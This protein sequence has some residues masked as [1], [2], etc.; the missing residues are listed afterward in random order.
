MS[1]ALEIKDFPGYFVTD[2]GDIYTRNFNKT[3]RFKKLK[4]WNIKYGY[5]YVD[6]CYKGK[7]F[8]KRI[9]RLVAQAFIPN[10]DNKPQV[11]HINGITSDNRVEN[12][13]WTTCSENNIHAY[14]VL[15][16]KPPRSMLGK[17]GKYNHTSKIVQQ[18]KD[19]KIIRCF[20]GT[21]E[22]HRETGI[23]FRCISNCCCG[24]QKTAGGYQ[25]K[26][27]EQGGLE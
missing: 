25:W 27:Q 20:N 15:K 10:R 22:A 8:H 24:R 7:R 23:N 26:Y 9:H 18:I 6:L 4:T 17:F 1:K 5:V 12:L 19:G 2:C 21:L 14:K 13:E 11:N 16:R 3:G